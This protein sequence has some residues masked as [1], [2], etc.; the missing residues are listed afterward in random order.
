[1]HRGNQMPGGIQIKKR[2]THN[3]K[4]KMPKTKKHIKIRDQ[5]PKAD[6]KGGRHN[7]PK[8]PQGGTNPQHRGGRHPVL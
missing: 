8:L 1:M 5:K 2:L 3:E 7:P 4:G 6:P